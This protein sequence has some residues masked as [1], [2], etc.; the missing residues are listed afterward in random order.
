MSQH[1]GSAGGELEMVAVV[2][3]SGVCRRR[4]YVLRAERAPGRERQ[5]RN[6]KGRSRSQMDEKRVSGRCECM[7]AQCSLKGGGACTRV[8]AWLCI[9]LE[10]FVED[11]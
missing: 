6:R 11:P 4:R 2:P 8:N 1:G 5:R 7:Y 10:H 3:P 9:A